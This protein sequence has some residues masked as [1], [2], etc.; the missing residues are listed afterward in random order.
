MVVGG[1]FSNCSEYIFSLKQNSTIAYN[2][3]YTWVFDLS[4]NISYNNFSS[5]PVAADAGDLLLYSF[6]ETDG[7]IGIDATPGFY[8][9]YNVSNKIL[10]GNMTN[11]QRF[12]ILIQTG[13]VQKSKQYA[14]KLTKYYDTPGTYTLLMWLQGRGPFKNDVIVTDGNFYS[15]F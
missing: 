1:I 4:L 13:P 7:R 3:K 8:S 15:F 5:E 14:S 11:F 2:V 12:S 9:D 10:I 6:N